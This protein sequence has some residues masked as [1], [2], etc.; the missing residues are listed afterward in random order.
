[1]PQRFFFRKE[2]RLSQKKTIQKVFQ[3]GI[4][5]NH[6]PF[7]IFIHKLE[8]SLT[9]RIQLL[10]SVPKKQFKKAVVRNLIKRRIREAYRLN[11]HILTDIELKPEIQIAIAFVY[12]ANEIHDFGFIH[13]KMIEVLKRINQ[14]IE[15]S[16]T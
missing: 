14:E 4:Q 3:E 12:I 2:D 9:G 16:I 6:Y 11:K 5:I 7:R 15:T 10:I 13:Q 1:M 8:K